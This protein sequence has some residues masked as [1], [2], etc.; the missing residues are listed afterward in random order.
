MDKMILSPQQVSANSPVGGKALYLYRLIK[1]GFPVPVSFFVT[2]NAKR[3]FVE[4]N[5]LNKP[6]ADYLGAIGNDKGENL[7][8]LRG[9][10]IN[11]FTQAEMPPVLVNE[12]GTVVSFFKRRDIRKL[13]VRSSAQSEDDQ[14]FSYAGLFESI[15]NV[16][17]NLAELTEAIKQVWLSAFSSRVAEYTLNHEVPDAWFQ[18]GVIIQEMV[19]TQ[20]SGVFFSIDPVSREEST[21]LIEF[22]DG[23]VE[24]LVQ[25]QVTPQRILVNHTNERIIDAG[26]LNE[27]IARHLQ[28]V[29][30]PCFDIEKLLNCKVDVEW[31]ISDDQV[32]ILQARPI[33]GS[34]MED[35]IWTDENVG[36]VIPDV[37]TPL[38][39]SI[40]EPITNTGFRRFVYKI[41]VKNYPAAGLFGLYAGKV[42]LNQT[43]FRK[44][45]RR[46]YFSDSEK[47]SAD[48]IKTLQRL[49][50]VLRLG[51][52]SLLLPGQIKRFRMN[53]RKQYQELSFRAGLNVKES[54]QYIRKQLQWHKKTIEIHISCTILAELYYQFLSNLCRRWFTDDSMINADAL[55]A[56][57][58][59]AES[60]ESG[61][62]LWQIS[63]LINKSEALRELFV[64]ADTAS[65]REELNL[66][67][68]GKAVLRSIDAFL[69][70]YGYGALHEFELYYPR[71]WEDESYIFVTLKNYL[72][73]KQDF[74]AQQL[75]TEQKRRQTKQAALQQLN[76]IRKLILQFILRQTKIF[77]TQRENIK[78]DFI[79]LHNELKKYLLHIGD[80]LRKQKIIEKK[81]DILFLKL[82]EI[83]ILILQD[84]QK[85]SVQER[86]VTRKQKRA[87]YS[88]MEHPKKIRQQGK[89]FFPLEYEKA[90]GNKTLAGIGCS[91]GI[92][93]GIVNIISKPESFQYFGKGEILVTKSTNPGWTPL[94]VLAGAVVTEIGGALSHGAII[95]RE[96]GIPMV[97]AVPG[98][99][100]KLESGMRVRV[101]GYTG[102][103]SILETMKQI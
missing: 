67:K 94:F 14:R 3:F 32:Y 62:V 31:A 81:D 9:E 58:H 33:T 73:N 51:I 54:M 2:F 103:I 78:Q 26:S 36:E 61:R 37:V 1:A 45:L 95:A 56:G 19:K 60:A 27:K 18:M 4:Y 21:S 5:K 82:E 43:A 79:R 7:L 55:L 49:F 46:F 12:L 90:E 50:A 68:D 102:E 29:L 101:N 83:E 75:Q 15:L 69:E 38:S 23:H 66:S 91:V 52:Y 59:A 98:V 30:Q 13:A 89:R 42:Y 87:R 70:K 20:M 25:G 53:H 74:A 34:H 93:E 86:I 80:I 44:L 10:L 22:V 47:T 11:R 72:I 24:N 16:N 77:S 8:L 71:W 39:W 57:L 65:L 28:K 92:T 63:Q 6:V 85:K 41:G 17:N 76:F 97:T 100:K 35:I 64:Q 40:L 96:Y 84:K 99:T 48:E 88:Q